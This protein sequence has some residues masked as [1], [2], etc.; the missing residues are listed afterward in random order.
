M[1]T[2]KDVEDNDQFLAQ[3]KYRIQNLKSLRIIALVWTINYMHVSK[4]L[5]N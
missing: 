4:I 2:G 3:W 1:W 5:Q